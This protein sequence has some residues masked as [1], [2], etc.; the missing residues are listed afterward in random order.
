MQRGNDCAVRER[1]LPFPKGRYRNVVAQLGAH[2]FQVASSQMIDG[3]QAPVTEP[4]RNFDS[5]DWRGLSIG[6]PRCG[7]HVG[8]HAGQRAG[9]NERES[10]PFHPSLSA[11]IIRFT[12]DVAA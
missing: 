10:D 8:D 4:R 12:V 1:E 5:V 11:Q 9:S 2:L 6:L 3:D 7:S